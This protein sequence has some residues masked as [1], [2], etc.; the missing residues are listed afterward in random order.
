M[1]KAVTYIVVFFAIIA[2]ATV[3]FTF[4]QVEQA[5]T[6]ATNSLQFRA[7]LLTDGLKEAVEPNFVNESPGYLQELVE[8][9]ANR[10]RIAGLAAIDSSGNI[11][12]ESSSLPKGLPESQKVA[13]QA[14]D[15]DSAA[16]EYTHQGSYYAY[17]TP[18]HSDHGVVGALLVVQYSDYVS[19]Q[20]SN[21]WKH[22]FTY[23][24]IQICLGL[25]LAW[26]VLR[27]FVYLPA[28]HVA[29]KIRVAR[30]ANDESGYGISDHHPLLEPLLK[31]MSQLQ[32][33]LSEAKQI[34]AEQ[35][36]QADS[37]EHGRQKR[38]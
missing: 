28:R 13:V 18:L 12:A 9:Y 24:L 29:A 30:W 4:N 20:L 35:M 17:A 5:K 23:L 32:N 11:L 21:I 6:D 31:E 27:W 16:G 38:E 34:I 19:T 37:N 3:L 2:L 33:E 36:S 7:S 8:K 10:K 26:L 1:K 22:N 15:T 25:T 14:M